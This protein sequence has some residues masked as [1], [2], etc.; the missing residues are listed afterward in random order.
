MHEKLLI[1]QHYA[2]SIQLTSVMHSKLKFIFEKHISFLLLFTTRLKSLFNFDKSCN[3]KNYLHSFMKP[4]TS[5]YPDSR[6]VVS[7]RVVVDVGS[8]PD[9]ARSH[10]KPVVLTNKQGWKIPQFGDVE[11]FED[12]SLVR[13]SIAIQRHREVVR[14]F[15][16]LREC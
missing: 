12:L 13:G 3:K 14:P 5:S 10:S 11:G 6:N 15:V 9:G 8:R 1:F 2:F 7:P 4:G 16:L